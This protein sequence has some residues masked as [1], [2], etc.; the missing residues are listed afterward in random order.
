M[1]AHIAAS[2]VWYFGAKPGRSAGDLIASATVAERDV[3]VR[4]VATRGTSN[5]WE[6]DV[7]DTEG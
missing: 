3:W 1:R 2:I 6:R 5:V 4:D 7:A